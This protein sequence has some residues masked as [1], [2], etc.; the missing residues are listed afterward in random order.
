MIPAP[1]AFESGQLVRILAGPGSG[2]Y[3]LIAGRRSSGRY[4]VSIGP[5]WIE[6]IDATR[7]AAAKPKAGPKKP[8][9]APPPAAAPKPAGKP[10]GGKGKG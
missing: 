8:A 1:H 6:F 3:G 7:L 4:P 5:R 10:K 2:S 9:A